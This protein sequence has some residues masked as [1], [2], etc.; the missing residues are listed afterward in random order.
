LQIKI[1]AYLRK[2]IC[3]PP[4]VALGVYELFILFSLFLKKIMEESISDF[5][6]SFISGL[7]L[8]ITYLLGGD[9]LSVQWPVVH[10][11]QFIFFV[12]V[13]ELIKK[14]KNKSVIVVIMLVLA[15]NGLSLYALLH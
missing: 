1:V 9:Y 15:L 5:I 13:W 3:Y 4:I 12:G 2:V 10:G 11:I 14:R 7:S 8:Y 6:I